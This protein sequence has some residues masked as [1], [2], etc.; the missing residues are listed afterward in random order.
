MNRGEPVNWIQ[1][2][3]GGRSQGVVVEDCC[4]DSRPGP[5]GCCR[6]QCWSAAV[7]YIQYINDWDDKIVN[8]V[9]KF[10]DDN[11]ISELQPTQCNTYYQ[12]QLPM[13]R[14]LKF[15]ATKIF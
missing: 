11:N 13:L 4:S 7:C 8:I 12:P 3:L 2:W 6:G 9:C 15:K 10:T 5:V 1:T 14:L